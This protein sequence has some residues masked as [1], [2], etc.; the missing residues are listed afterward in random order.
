VN[1]GAL[2]IELDA[3]FDGPNRCV[4]AGVQRQSEPLDL[5]CGQRQPD[6]SQERAQQPNVQIAHV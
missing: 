1:S 2:G 4:G 3:R 6:R 5:I